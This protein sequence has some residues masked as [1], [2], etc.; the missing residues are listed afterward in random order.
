[1][2][3]PALTDSFEKTGMLAA[4]G[5]CK[6]FDADADGYVRAEGCG[7]VLLKRLADA[8]RDGDKVWGVLCGSAL[9]QD[10]R[11]NGLTA[12]NGLAQQSVVREALERSGVAAAEVSYVEAHGTGTSLGDPIE[13]NAL[14]RVLSRG[15]QGDQTCWLGSLKANLGHL[16]AAAGIAGLIKV[17]LCMEHGALPPHPHLGQLNP[18]MELEGTAFAINTTLQPWSG[19]HRFAGISSFGFGG[20]N[21]HLIVASPPAWQRPDAPPFQE[22]PEHLL[23]LSARSPGALNELHQ[24]YSALLSSRLPQLDVAD[25]CYSANVGRS[26]LPCRATWVGRDALEL[27][28]ALGSNQLPSEKVSSTPT[29]AFLFSGQGSQYPGMGG[30]LLESQPVFREVIIDCE[31]ILVNLHVLPE[32]WTLRR[33]LQHRP[34]PNAS[35]TAVS[36]MLEQT[37]ITQPVLFSLEVA[38]ARLWMSWGV[39]P[40]WVLGHSVGEIAAACVAG[41]FDLEEGLRLIADRSRLMA[42]LPAGGGMLAL[43]SDAPTVEALLAEHT[44]PLVIAADNGPGNVVI[45]GPL[46]AIAALEPAIAA[47]GIG[48]KRLRVSHAFHS[49]LMEP[50]LAEFRKLASAIRYREPEIPIISNITHAPIGAAMADPDYWCRHISAPVLYGRAVQSLRAHGVTG[51]LEIGPKPTLIEMACS[52]G[53]DPHARWLPSLRPSRS[54]TRQMLESLA[55]L[56][57]LGTPIDWAGFDAPFQRRRLSLPTYPWQHT[58]YWLPAPA[59]IPAAPIA[60]VEPAARA[61]PAFPGLFTSGWSPLPLPPFLA[62]EETPEGQWLF[63]GPRPIYERFLQ[64]LPACQICCW[65]EEHSH[66]LEVHPRHWQLDPST[67]EHWD[68]LFQALATTSPILGILQVVGSAGSSTQPGSKGKAEPEISRLLLRQSFHWPLLVQAVL[69]SDWPAQPPRLWWLNSAVA[70]DSATLPFQLEQGQALG[71]ARCL[72]L[73]HPELWGGW[74]DFPVLDSDGAM[75]Q[76]LAELAQSCRLGPRDRPRELQV[77]FHAGE[78]QVARLEQLLLRGGW[79]SSACRLDGH[80]LISGGLGALGLESAAWL[81]DHG[82]PSLILVGRQPPSVQTEA[83]L[84]AWRQAGA[85]ITVLQA[86]IADPAVVPLLSQAI[87]ASG[88]PLRGVVHAAGV[89][90][91]ASVSGLKARG[92]ERVQRAKALGAWQLHRLSQIH[93]VDVFILYSSLSTLLGSPGQSAY[94]AANGAL[95]ALARYRRAQGLPAISMNWG[96]WSGGGMAERNR[97]QPGRSLQAYGVAA[98]PASSYLMVLE[99]LF[100]VRDED[101]PGGG[102]RANPPAVVGVANL[103]LETLHGVVGGRPQAMFLSGLEGGHR[104]GSQEGHES[105]LQAQLRAIA[106]GARAERLFLYLQTTMSGLLALSA[107]EIGPDLHLVETGADSLVVMEALSQ[108]QGDLGLMIYPRELYAH[109]RIGALATYLAEAF[110]AKDGARAP[111][112]TPTAALELPAALRFRSS[113]KHRRS[114]PDTPKLPS[115]LFL[116]SSPRAGSTLLRVMLAGHP[117]LFSPPELH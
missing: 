10:G 84:A 97:I 52:S 37:G 93:P 73:E 105:P 83:R 74:L 32:G 115:A 75:A 2:L 116:L 42:A 16:E 29:L 33:F 13:V 19:A 107:E 22:R 80:V 45:A 112:P 27:E 79:A 103:Q 24:R 65:I 18:L 78:R 70:A 46:E 101:A 59:A 100:R 55:A 15:R 114:S 67:A 3:S 40:D 110:T 87:Q 85:L 88:L 99:P 94:G 89:L 43:F 12:P 28:E 64:A 7:V 69:E 58:P 8:R 117:Q 111:S 81:L 98:L 76:L 26:H 104:A 95:D 72:A 1:M 36:A 54:D 50:M 25:L 38:L 108:I 34:E 61:T 11:S 51:Y 90:E 57:R 77:R 35:D 30:E 109:P 66:F 102:E 41:V 68:R 62:S 91:D 63:I 17:L 60:N 48:A 31:Q 14:R 9:N 39:R 86:D 113:A 23:T 82:V 47:R 92:W 5:R 4:D 56:Y 53:V 44:S 49:P 106:P 71:F 20:T 96:P 21:A 6:T